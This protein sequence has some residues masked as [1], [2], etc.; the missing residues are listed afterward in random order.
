MHIT[1]NGCLKAT[2]FKWTYG[3]CES[4]YRF[5]TLPNSY[6]NHHAKFEIERIIKGEHLTHS[7][8]EA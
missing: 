6:R 4:D 5:S 7:K 3:L 1:K 2:C 8:G